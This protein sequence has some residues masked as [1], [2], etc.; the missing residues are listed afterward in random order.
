[1]DSLSRAEFAI[2]IDA[3][4]GQ[5]PGAVTERRIDPQSAGS[6]S[7]THHATPEAL[8]A[9][10]LVLYGHAPEAVMLS[11]AG[12][13]FSLGAGLSPLVL[14]GLEEIVSIVQRRIVA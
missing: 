11:V 14:S 6:A 2:F 13:D 1:M 4:S 3:G 7:F 10:A 9:G 5:E 12:T 8:L